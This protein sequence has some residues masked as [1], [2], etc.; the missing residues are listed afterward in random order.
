MTLFFIFLQACFMV[1]FLLTINYAL[2][3]YIVL[4]DRLN[5]SNSSVCFEYTFIKEGKEKA[6]LFSPNYVQ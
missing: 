5:I 3:T 1:T 4:N 6:Y 2:Q